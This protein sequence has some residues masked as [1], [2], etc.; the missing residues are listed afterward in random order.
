MKK[1][2]IKGKRIDLIIPTMKDVDDI[3]RNINDK[4]VA[5]YMSNVPH[6]YK[7]KDGEFFIKKIVKKGLKAKTDYPLSIYEKQ[8]KEVI[9]GIGLHNIDKN[10]QRAEVGYWLG[11][12][13]WRQGYISEA[14]GMILNF[15]F[16]RLKLRKIWAG[17]YH[18]NIPSQKLLMKAGFAK[19][20][21]LRKHTLKSSKE[22]DNVMFGMLREEYER[23][24]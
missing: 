10:N 19:E 13:Y 2:V 15:G 8:K 3:C 20:G 14:L 1:L 18:P 9:G 16:R 7:R 6:P 5:K 24:K 11:R 21:L 4:L 23:K 12:K 22:Y 17:V